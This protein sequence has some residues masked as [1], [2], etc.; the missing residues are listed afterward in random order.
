MN[1]R[2]HLGPSST[3]GSITQLPLGSAVGSERYPEVNGFEPGYEPTNT[4]HDCTAA[5]AEIERLTAEVD[6]LRKR[7]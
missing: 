2:L 3:H 7:V 6:L 4:P 5:E 1:S